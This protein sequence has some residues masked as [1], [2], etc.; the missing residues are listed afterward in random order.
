MIVEALYGAKD[1]REEEWPKP[2]PKSG[3]VR[4]QIKSVCIGEADVALFENGGT[5]FEKVPVPFL[6]GKEVSGII[7]SVGSEVTKLKEG[8]PAVIYPYISCGKCEYCVSGKNKL[9]RKNKILGMPPDHGALAEYIVVPS[10]NVFPVKGK[11]SFAEI[12]CVE[13]LARGICA[14][15]ILG[16]CP[17]ATVAIFGADGLGLACLIAAK[18]FGAK[19]I[20]VTDSTVSKLVVSEKYGAEN[21]IN[22]FKKDVSEEIMKLTSDKGVDLAFITSGE[23]QSIIDAL[24]SLSPGGKIAIVG[25]P[26]ENFWKIPSSIFS[27]KETTIKTVQHSKSSFITAIDWIVENK[28]DLSHLISQRMPW[29]FSEKAFEKFSDLDEGILRISLEPEEPEESFYI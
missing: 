15:R 22:S 3:E 19:I 13:S 8:T 16:T 29:E 9:C 17:E 14:S 18:T 28:V 7:D 6:L 11:V 1:I 26:L 2:E 21:I 10:E 25:R 5:D 23:N 12:A 27:E 20:A 4:V 24:K